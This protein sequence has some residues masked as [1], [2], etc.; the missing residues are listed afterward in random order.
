L[1]HGLVVPLVSAAASLAAT[2]ARAR[3]EQG[4]RLAYERDM[5]VDQGGLTQQFVYALGAVSF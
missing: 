1:R 5:P 2:P 4:E 3:D